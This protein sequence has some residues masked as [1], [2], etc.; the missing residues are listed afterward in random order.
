MGV[1]NHQAE[2]T[3]MGEGTEKH[4]ERSRCRVAGSLLGEARMY[5]ESEEGAS[6]G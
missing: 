1:E 5:K 4:P 6:D 3:T 2:K